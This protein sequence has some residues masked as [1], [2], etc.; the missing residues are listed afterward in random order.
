MVAAL[1]REGD[2]W[3]ETERGFVVPDAWPQQAVEKISG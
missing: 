2:I 1:R 3:L